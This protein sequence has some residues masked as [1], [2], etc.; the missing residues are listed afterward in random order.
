MRLFAV[1]HG[2]LAAVFALIAFMLLGAALRSLW[3]TVAGGLDEGSAVTLIEAM[4]VTAVAV[5]A[6][7]IAQTIAEEE[8]VREAHVSAPTRV[9]RFLSRFIVVIAIAL[10]VEAL[11]GTMKALH[12]DMT[13]LPH[14]AACVVGV[15]LL[16]AAWGYFVRANRAAEDIEPEAMAQAKDEDRK[17]D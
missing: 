13:L 5:V 7:Q 2:I 9:R 14:A 12:E 17:L 8:V 6:L 10:A 4:G 11:V 15:A 3:Q 1:V 16:V